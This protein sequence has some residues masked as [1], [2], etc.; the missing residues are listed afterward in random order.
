MSLNASCAV[1]GKGDL[2][3]QHA[4]EEVV[5]NKKGKDLKG[6]PGK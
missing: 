6:R 3:K 1:L 4:K 2:G 5:G